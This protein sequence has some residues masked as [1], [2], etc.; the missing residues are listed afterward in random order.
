MKKVEKEILKE[1]KWGEFLLPFYEKYCFSNITN[2]IKEFFKIRDNSSS[3]IIPKHLWKKEVQNSD[4]II[5]FFIDG[6]GYYQW[7]KYYEKLNFFKNFTANGKIIPLTTIFPSTTAATVTTINS[8]LTPNRHGLPEWTV[9]FKEIDMI[10]NTLPFMPILKTDRKSFARKANPGILFKGKTI[11]QTLKENRIK[12]FTFLSSAYAFSEYSNLI[13]RGS[14]RIPFDDLADLFSKLVKIVERTKGKAYFYVYIGNIDGVAHE[15]GPHT[16][17]YRTELEILNY[18]LQNAFV[19]QI[20]KKVA[21]K[22]TVMITADHGEINVSPE[23]TYYL[24]KFNALR[25]N[26]AK[27]KNGKTILPT[28]SARD[29]FIHVK[30]GKIDETKKFLQNKLRKIA[31]VIAIKEAFKMN[32]FG[33]GEPTKQLKDRVGDLLVLPYKNHVIWYK[34]SKDEKFKLRGHHGGLSKDEMMTELAIAKLDDLI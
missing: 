15:F 18:L 17:E 8:G 34:H 12:S 19:N 9:Y 31:K 24:N 13:Y 26:F 20:N 14:R 27:S 29:I 6:F 16:E 1:K 28:G 5:M 10:I 33:I 4:K 7:T 11:Y 30:N 23:K 2:V 22:T 3:A 32:L 25:K 21:S